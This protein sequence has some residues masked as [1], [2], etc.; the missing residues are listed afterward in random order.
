MEFAISFLAASCAAR[1]ISHPH[2]ISKSFCRWCQKLRA[3]NSHDLPRIDLF[4]AEDLW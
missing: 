4:F 1:G 3:F 2:N